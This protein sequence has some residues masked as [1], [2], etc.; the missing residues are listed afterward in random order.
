MEEVPEVTRMTCR[1][2]RVVQEQTMTASNRTELGVTTARILLVG[3]EPD[4]FDIGPFLRVLA[5]RY[6][7]LRMGK[8]L[9]ASAPNTLST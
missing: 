3:V 5:S 7:L 9:S 1:L 8:T 4:L 6:T 2:K